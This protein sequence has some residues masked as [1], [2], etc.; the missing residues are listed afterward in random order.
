M[1]KEDVIA[2]TRDQIQKWFD[3][4]VFSKKI[5]DGTATI[6]DID[7]I[8]KNT[9]NILV[10][11]FKRALGDAYELDLPLG[12]D[13]IRSFL[14]KAMEN[15]YDFLNTVSA[16]IQHSVD[17]QK[18]LRIKAQKVSFPAQRVDKIA[19]AAGRAEDPEK[20]RRIIDAPVRNVI[21]SFTDD[22]VRAN[23][24]FRSRAGL[25][26][27]IV[28]RTDGSCCEWCSKLAG[29][30]RYP[31]EVPKDV[32]RRHD[33]CTCT[34]TYING[35]SRQDVW[36]KKTWNADEET[37]EKRKELAA[38]KP[39]VL[40]KE[41]AALREQEVRGKYKK[42][43]DISGE[44]GIIKLNRKE[45]N[46]GVFLSLDIPMQKRAVL[47][48]CREYSIEIKGI[49]FKI[50]RSEKLIA[51]P[52]YGS[53]D[54]NNIGR[55]D[56]FPQAFSSEEELLKTILHEKCHVI[57]LKKYGK[58]YAQRN[59]DVMEKQAYRFESIFYN[60]IRKR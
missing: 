34:V 21:D 35:K 52:F 43:V 13:V 44:S 18:G 28:R 11:N 40:T 25:E 6:E 56:L 5:R 42:K 41:Q 19:A 53:A 27:H 58:E 24:D 33:N 7:R 46:T 57:Q 8:A 17:L 14:P 32:F 9:A 29:K 36:S 1:N 55:I 26:T 49:T 51:M 39:T 38:K 54:Y 23:A 12:E 3:S 50:Q 15:N 30:Y 60:I 4:S 48:L 2:E 31:D 45:R 10:T 37:I 59:L 22:Y 16:Q 47:S 20:L